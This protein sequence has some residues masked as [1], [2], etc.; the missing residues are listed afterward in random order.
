LISGFDRTQRNFIAISKMIIRVG[1]HPWVVR[2]R[3]S[4]NRGGDHVD[5]GDKKMWNGESTHQRGIFKKTH[6][7]ILISRGAFAMKGMLSVHA[8]E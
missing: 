2:C 1:Y 6:I 3:G 4:V 5:R 7:D 8:S